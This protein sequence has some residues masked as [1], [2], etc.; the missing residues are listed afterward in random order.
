MQRLARVYPPRAYWGVVAVD[1][2][3]RNAEN[4][5]TQRFLTQYHRE[6]SHRHDDS[7]TQI[8]DHLVNDSKSKKV[9]TNQT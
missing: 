4:A 2:R 5:K 7:K 3:E 1:V 6:A 9:G 8:V